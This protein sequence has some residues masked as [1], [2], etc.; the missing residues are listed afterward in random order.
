MWT[1]YSTKDTA[2]LV[3]LTQSVVR[4]CVREGLLDAQVDVFPLRFSFQDLTVL[5]VIK[6]LVGRGVSIRRARRQLGVLRARNPGNSLASLAIEVHRGHV[7]T[8]R[9]IY[10]AGTET[11]HTWYRGSERGFQRTVEGLRN[12]YENG[13]KLT[14]STDA[15][16]YVPGLHRGEV[17]INFLDTWKA[18]GIP[19]PDI[20]KAMTVNGYEVCEI[21]DERG[22]I[23]E[24]FAADLIEAPDGR[25]EGLGVE[26]EAGVRLRMKRGQGVRARRPRRPASRRRRLRRGLTRAARCPPSIR[27]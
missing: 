21:E 24:G 11:P 22:P 14:F 12:A 23:K 27:C 17:T 7:V 2:Q 26:H 20:L 13:V 4:S 15:D 6:Q 25:G 16:Y 3:G 18:A 8:E 10:R 1:A 19:A 9:G 5:K